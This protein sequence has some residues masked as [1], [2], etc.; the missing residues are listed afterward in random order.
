MC[1][2]DILVVYFISF[3]LFKS[4]ISLSLNLRKQSKK[5]FA[6]QFHKLMKFYLHLNPF[7]ST[8][9]LTESHIVKYYESSLYN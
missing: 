4:T 5:K 3:G 2:D 6:I 1:I 7:S 8:F 9:D